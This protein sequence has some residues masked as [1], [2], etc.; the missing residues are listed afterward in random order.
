MISINCER[1]AN[2]MP[3]ASNHFATQINGMGNGLW[4]LYMGIY[5]QLW[6]YNVLYTPTHAHIIVIKME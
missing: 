2:Q 3:S 6:L 5:G 4:H 1:F